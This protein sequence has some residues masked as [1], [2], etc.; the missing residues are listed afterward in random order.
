MRKKNMM[1]LTENELL[2]ISGGSRLSEALGFIYE[3]I[4]IACEAVV[5]SIANASGDWLTSA[6]SQ[7][8]GH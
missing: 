4:V 8:Y 5:D 6:P 3:T 1:E 2:N 7:I